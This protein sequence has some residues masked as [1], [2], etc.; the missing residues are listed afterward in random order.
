MP[1]QDR[2]LLG[3]S[4]SGTDWPAALLDL[5]TTHWA[6]MVRLARL[7]TATDASSEEIVQEAFLRVR[8]KWD[9][10]DNA[11]A[12]LR[13]RESLD[14]VLR[15]GR[16][17]V[18]GASELGPYALLLKASSRGDLQAFADRSLQPIVEHDRTRGSELLPTLRAYLEE[19]RV[20]RRVAERCV[21]H[22]NT[23]VY[24]IRR[25]EELLKVDLGDPA[26]VFDLTLAVRI[27]DLLGD[28]ARLRA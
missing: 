26:T 7:L 19:D 1:D 11:P 15:L 27:R 21:I 18:V 2:A 5:Y 28:G 20:Q 13:A 12:Y 10:I 22:V 16:T 6:R 14:L 23:V 9:T 24:R 8:A 4:V 17:G 25:I 3:M